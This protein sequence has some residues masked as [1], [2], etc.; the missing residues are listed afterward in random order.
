MVG[1]LFNLSPPDMAPVPDPAKARSLADARRQTHHAAQLATAAGISFLPKQADD[2]HTNLEWLPDLGALASRL[3]PSSDPFRVG[4]RVAGLELF[5]L[6]DGNTVVDSLPL[7]GQTITDAE[8][9]LRERVG[10]RGAQRSRFTLAKHYEIPHH[11]VDDGKPFDA[12]DRAAFN[13]LA[14]WFALGARQLER[15]RVSNASSEVRCWPHHFDIATLIDVAPEKTVGVGMEPGD[16]YY[17]EPYFYVNARPEPPA[18]AV[19][20][21]LAGAGSWHTHEWFGAVLP[22]SRIRS[23]DG[24]SQ[25]AEFVESAIA[26][27]REFVEAR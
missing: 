18:D 4:V 12:S 7:D 27:C 25:V 10:R 6:D 20:V 16:V 23:S 15:V 19:S 24:E 13:E 2:S 14:A 8:S 5:L 3:V 21:P 22:G 11:A 17:D 26:V 1:H 9:W